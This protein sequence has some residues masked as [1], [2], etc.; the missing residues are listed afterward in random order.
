MCSCHPLHIPT[1]S[2]QV[3]LS[4]HAI[5]SSPEIFSA[6][7]PLPVGDIVVTANTM[8]YGGQAI[9]SVNNQHLCLSRLVCQ[10]YFWLHVHQ[11]KDAKFKSTETDTKAKP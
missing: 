9:N 3:H 6:A 7:A 2:L 1:M 10:Q 5:L 11:L 8:I 4:L